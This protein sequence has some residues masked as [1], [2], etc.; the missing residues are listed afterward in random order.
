MKLT[1]DEIVTLTGGTLVRPGSAT[2]I[3]GLASLDEACAEDVSFLGNEKYYK[4]F[5]QTAAAVV[6]IPPDVPEQPA[7]SALI[8]VANPSLAFGEMVKHFVKKRQAFTPGVHPAAHVADN[9]TFDPSQVCIKPGAVVE[10]GAH[11]GAGTE[12]GPGAV[13]GTDVRIGEDCTLY[14]NVTVREGCIIGNRVTLH[15]GCVIGSDGY[16]YELVDGRHQKI[17]QVGIVLLEDDVEIGANSTVDRARFGKTLI[18]EGTKVDNL[19]QIG[20]NA[21]VGKHC[22]AVAQ[23]GISGST[24]LG[25]YVTMAAKSGCVGHIKI[26]DHAV[27]TAKA[28]A[29]GDLEGGQVY[30]GM[31]ARPMRETL[32]SKARIARLPK[33]MAEVKEMR[34]KLD[35]LN[36]AS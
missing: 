20:H 32:K 31:P 27:L 34:R 19:V 18:G 10:S 28:A 8:E 22:L 29:M 7:E 17:D 24:H 26:G 36:P 3:T 16:G 4:E 35:Q 2:L 11:I 9:V 33:L 1:L 6:L 13:V 30:M 21:Q 15:S 23:C 14:A 12:I 5:L 25:D